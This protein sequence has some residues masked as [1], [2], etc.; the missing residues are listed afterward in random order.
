MT[1]FIL[2]K[3]VEMEDSMAILLFSQTL[4]LLGSHLLALP[5][6]HGFSCL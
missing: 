6:S 4:N 5:V 2:A 3:L 1:S